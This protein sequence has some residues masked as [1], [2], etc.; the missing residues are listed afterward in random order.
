VDEAQ[1]EAVQVGLEEE[2]AQADQMPRGIMRL[3]QPEDAA[4]A[5]LAVRAERIHLVARPEAR[6]ERVL[7]LAPMVQAVAVQAAT[8]RLAAL[9]GC[10]AV[11][12]EAPVC[13]ALAVQVPQTV[14]LAG[15]G[16]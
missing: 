15:R 7:N 2:A 1:T 11:E 16:S 3:E 12:E 5:R 4:M 14:E 13:K 10:M 8:V 6:V 9:A